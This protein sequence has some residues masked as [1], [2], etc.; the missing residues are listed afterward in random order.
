MNENSVD[1]ADARP[2]VTVVVLFRERY[3]LTEAVI[4]QI[5][6]TIRIPVR[7]IYAD[8]GTPDDLRA[9]I[10]ARA[11][12]WGLEVVRF[13]ERLWPTQVRLRIAELIDTKYA[14]FVDNDIHVLPGWLE[15]LIDCAEE[16]GAG[17]VGPLYLWGD[18]VRSER[19]HMAGGVLSK[20]SDA[21]GTLLYERHRHVNR[22]ASEL[23]LEREP[24]DFVE[25][26]CL[27]MRRELYQSPGMFDEQIVCVHEHIHAALLCR[28]MGYP[29]YMEPSARVVYL[30]YV[31]YALA[32]L[33]HFR[34]RW[35]FEAAMSTI[36]AFAQRWSLVNDDRVF[37]VG[38]FLVSHCSEIDPVRLSLQDRR[39]NAPMQE[40]DLKQTIT[41]LLE[42]A[43]ARGYSERDLTLFRTA[44]WNALVLSSGGY[45]PCGRP[46]I[47]HLIGTAGVLVHFGLEARLV[48]VALLHAAYTHAPRM[49]GGPQITVN[50][51]AGWLGG[52]DAPVERGVRGCVLRSARWKELSVLGN[53]KDVATTEDV[54]TALI[55]MASLVDMQLSG[56]IRATGRVDDE[57]IAA[58]AKADEICAVIGIPGLAASLSRDAGGARVNVFSEDKRPSESFRL[59]GQKMVRMVN[60]AIFDVQRS[61]AATSNSTTEMTAAETRAAP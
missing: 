6:R 51:V 59:E 25:F 32:D 40:S 23:E 41:G 24:T 30:A 49:T 13:G 54:D 14:V 36:A 44:H 3:G 31:P 22:Q 2:I 39:A 57:D 37:G 15:R 58:I 10:D 29:I 1:Q 27:L 55:A 56:E 16:T 43:R 21:R 7:L 38:K 42:L 33:D 35:S 8:A 48:V 18:N 61:L 46:F 53:W 28:E 17:L 11:A 47:N 12:E 9:R 26:H 5:A 50:T 4:E 52:A 60:N 45:R 34:W 20:T 19:V